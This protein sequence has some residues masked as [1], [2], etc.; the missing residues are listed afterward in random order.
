MSDRGVRRLPLGRAQD[1]FLV[2]RLS[3]YVLRATGIHGRGHS[4]NPSVISGK[5][6]IGTENYMI[7]RD[8][9]SA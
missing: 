4:N 2:V 9:E 7:R 6:V 8:G 5:A 1:P 3:Y